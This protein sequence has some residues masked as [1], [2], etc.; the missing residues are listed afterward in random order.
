MTAKTHKAFSVSFALVA[1]M[2]M[3][4]NG[5]S[6]V[7]YYMCL[8]VMLM[9]SKAGALFPDV[10]HIWKNVKEK[11]AINWVINKIIHI[12]GG[13]H[14]SWQ[15]HSIDICTVFT[16]F[17]F[18]FPGYLMNKGYIDNTNKEVMSLLLLGFACGWI[19]HLYSD[20]LTIGG[21]RLLCFVDK[22]LRLVPKQ[23]FGLRFS[24]GDEWEEFNYKLMRILN[25]FIGI[26][27]LIYP[28]MGQIVER[29]N[30]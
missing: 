24:T 4:R 18:I 1:T 20:M 13:T 16:L 8:V 25:I 12:T 15:T 3:L 14:R 26:I 11:T 23:L 2:I 17:A 19:S 21:V 29:I 7:N 27:A 28:F 5:V 22:K 9:A 10:D 30:L 6:S